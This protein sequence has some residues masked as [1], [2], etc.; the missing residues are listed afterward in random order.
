MFFFTD[1]TDFIDFRSIVEGSSIDVRTNKKTCCRI[2]PEFPKENT[3]SRTPEGAARK[4]KMPQNRTAILKIAISIINQCDRMII[5]MAITITILDG[6]KLVS[7]KL[8]HPV[9]LIVCCYL[10]RCSFNICMV[11]CWYLY[12]LLLIVALFFVNMCIDL[13]EYLYWLF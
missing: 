1:L 10:Y 9:C 8:G 12:W 4:S 7:K 13:L 11:F 2:F 3:Q 5:T 6:K